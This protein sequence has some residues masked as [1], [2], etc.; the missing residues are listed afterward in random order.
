MPYKM[1]VSVSN[2]FAALDK[3]ANNTLY[4]A[5][6]PP[7]AYYVASCPSE[8]RSDEQSRFRQAQAP[9]LQRTRPFASLRVTELSKE[10]RALSSRSFPFG[11]K[12]MSITTCGIW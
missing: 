4:E 6:D 8:E 5:S 2:K 12:M 7:D 10:T 3:L 9:V 11:V 1:Q